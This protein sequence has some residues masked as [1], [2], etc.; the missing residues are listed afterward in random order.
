MRAKN[1]LNLTFKRP[2][3]LFRVTIISTY[4]DSDR[5]SNGHKA[6]HPT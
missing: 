1:L 2:F 5:S 6:F 4:S 3:T